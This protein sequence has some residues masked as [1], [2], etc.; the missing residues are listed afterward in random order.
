MACCPE[1]EA[2]DAELQ[3]RALS[4]AW[5]TIRALTGGM[6][7]GCPVEMRPCLTT[8]P[9]SI[10]MGGTWHPFIDSNGNWRNCDLRRTMS[11]SC[12]DMA[13]ISFP[14]RAAAL[15]YVT[16][17]GYYLDNR[18]FRIDNGNKLVRQDGR[19]FPRCQNLGAPAGAIG[20]MVVSYYPGILPTEAGLWAIGVLGC[21][22][23][24]ACSG[25]KCR[26]PGGV[27]ALVRQGLSFTIAASMFDGGTGI[28][29]VDAY[30]NSVNPNKLSGPSLVWSP[31][32]PQSRHRITTWTAPVPP[33]P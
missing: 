24:K 18:T 5:G 29:E 4:L 7:G 22:F 23:A 8:D 13:E 3:T 28:R 27:T 30:V 10:C 6:V 1:W 21:E 11:C 32:L 2:Y 16:I 9:C 17:D 15:E 26:L 25:G 31:D 14:G 20:T 12:C 19:G 33:T